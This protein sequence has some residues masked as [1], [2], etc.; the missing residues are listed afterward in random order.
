MST[1]P[2]KIKQDSE[3]EIFKDYIAM[4]LRI[5]ANNT[6]NAERSCLT[7]DYYEIIHPE[8]EENFEK[9]EITE[10]IKNKLR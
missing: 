2:Y 10:K 7:K 3:N 5:I 6:A 1:L 4:S 8:K 9:G